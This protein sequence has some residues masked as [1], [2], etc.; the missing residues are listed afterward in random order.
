MAEQIP[1][2]ALDL[3]GKP[4]LAHLATIMPDGTTHVTPVW[5]DYDGVSILINTVRGRRKERDIPLAAYRAGLFSILDEPGT[6]ASLL[7]VGGP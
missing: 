2:N 1:E 4:A 6:V 5:V 3:F 7:P